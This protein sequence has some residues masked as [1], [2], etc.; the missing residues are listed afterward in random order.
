MRCDALRNGDITEKERWLLCPVCDNKTRTK[1]REDTELKN[2]PMFCAKCKTETIIT[3]REMNVT[4][5][6]EPVA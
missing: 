5:I 4:V 6:I 1:V 3:V 2:F